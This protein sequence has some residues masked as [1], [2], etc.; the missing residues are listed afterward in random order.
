VVNNLSLPGTASWST[1]NTVT[2]PGVQLNAGQNT[3]SLIYNSS[4]GSTNYVNLDEITLQ[5]TGGGEPGLGRS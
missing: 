1:W 5:Y 2:V 4:L 3:V